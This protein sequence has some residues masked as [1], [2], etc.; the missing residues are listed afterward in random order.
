MKKSL[1]ILSSLFIM[2][3][4]AF[5]K[6]APANAYNDT[7]TINGGTILGGKMIS[8]D[9]SYNQL[10][11]NS[12]SMVETAPVW[13]DPQK[14]VVDVQVGQDQAHMCELIISDID[15]NPPHL[16]S[17]KC[18]GGYNVSSFNP[19]QSYTNVEIDLAH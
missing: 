3:G 11:A 10:N 16:D 14:G 19:A 4:S 7:F 5:A 13:S 17:Q 18:V 2:S 8:G 12:F 1:V 9:A 15:F 6:A